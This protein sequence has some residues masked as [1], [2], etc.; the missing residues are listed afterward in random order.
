MSADPPVRAAMTE[1]L[2]A[3]ATEVRLLSTVNPQVLFQG[4]PVRTNQY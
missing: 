2:A 1:A 4:G 3:D